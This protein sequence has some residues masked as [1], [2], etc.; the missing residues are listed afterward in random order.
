MPTAESLHV[1]DLGRVTI[2]QT[3]PTTLPGCLTR[4]HTLQLGSYVRSADQE[5]ATRLPG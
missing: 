4:P 2:G 5:Q 3:F 1:S